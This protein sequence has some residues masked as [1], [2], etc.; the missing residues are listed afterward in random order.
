MESNLTLKV[1]SLISARTRIEEDNLKGIILHT[2]DTVK[3]Q[4]L[5]KIKEASPS[6]KLN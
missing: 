2:E 4:Q 6:V 1:S 5:E 3:V